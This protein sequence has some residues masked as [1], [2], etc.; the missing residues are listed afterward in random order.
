MG[1]SRIPIY[2][3]SHPKR[4]CMVTPDPETAWHTLTGSPSRGERCGCEGFAPLS[5]P[6]SRVLP[7]TQEERGTVG[8]MARA[9]V[10][11]TKLPFPRSMGGRGVVRKEIGPGWCGSVD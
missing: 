11:G 4:K 9:L 1:S 5:V 3:L 10:A 7:L 8:S 6:G 2:N